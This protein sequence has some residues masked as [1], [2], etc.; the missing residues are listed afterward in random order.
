MSENIFVKESDMKQ[1]PSGIQHYLTPILYAEKGTMPASKKTSKN[2]LIIVTMAG[3]YFLRSKIFGNSKVRQFISTYE[4]IEI[5]KINETKRLI[6]CSGYDTYF[7]ADHADIAIAELLTARA[8]LFQSIDDPNP[9]RVKGYMNQPEFT[10]DLKVQLTNISVLRYYCLVAFTKSASNDQMLI[11][12][13]NIDE[14]FSP[15]VT[16]TRDCVL[17]ENPKV[18]TIPL[19][20]IKHIRQIGFDNVEPRFV[21]RVVHK[22]LKNTE[23][24]KSIKLMNYTDFIPEQLRF[25]RI[26]N[27]T[28]SIGFTK[29]KFTT[30]VWTRIINQFESLESSILR[31]SI[32]GC[33]LTQEQFELIVDALCRCRCFRTLEMLEIDSIKFDGHWKPNVPNKSTAVLQSSRFLAVYSI[34]NWEKPSSFSIPLFTD[35]SMLSEICLRGQDMSQQVDAFT[36][37]PNIRT[38][39]L[40]KCH[41]TFQSLRAFFTALSTCNRRINLSLAN[42]NVPFSH[43]DTLFDQINTVPRSR[44]L[45]EL[46]WSGNKIPDKYVK[47]LG[48]FF[49][50]TNPIFYLS[51]DCIFPADKLSLLDEFL[52]SSETKKIWGIS[53]KGN[54]QANVGAKLDILIKILEKL[55][56]LS[57]LDISG[58]KITAEHFKTLYEFVKARKI[59]E[60]SLDGSGFTTIDKLYESY[61]TLSGIPTLK[62]LGRPFQDLDRLKANVGDVKFKK[63]REKIRKFNIPA[64]K[65]IRDMYYIT[66]DALKGFNGDSMDEY[67]KIYPRDLLENERP[68]AYLILPEPPFESRPSLFSASSRESTLLLEEIQNLSLRPP[69][70]PPLNAAPSANFQIPSCLGRVASRPG[71]LHKTTTVEESKSTIKLQSVAETEEFFKA[72]ELLSLTVDVED[73]I[74]NVDDLDDVKLKIDKTE[75]KP[76]SMRVRGAMP[77][78]QPPQAA[79][80]PKINVNYVEPKKVKMPA[81]EPVEATLI[82]MS[83]VNSLAQPSVPPK[84]VPSQFNIDLLDKSP[85]KNDSPDALLPPPLQSVIPHNNNVNL[86]TSSFELPGDLN[87]GVPKDS[88]LE[89]PP[90]LST[91]MSNNYSSNNNTPPMIPPMLSMN[92][93]PSTSPST[94]INLMSAM[95]TGLP[96]QKSSIPPLVFPSDFSKQGPPVIQPP[97]QNL[98]VPVMERKKNDEVLIQELPNYGAPPLNDPRPKKSTS[99]DIFAPTPD[100]ITVLNEW[101]V[102]RPVIPVTP[103]PVPV[104]PKKA[105]EKPQIPKSQPIIPDELIFGPKTVGPAITKPNPP[106]VFVFSN[107]PEIQPLSIPPMANSPI[108]IPNIVGP[109]ADSKP[110]REQKVEIKQQPIIDDPFAMP[111]LDTPSSSKPKQAA[112]NFAPNAP[113]LSGF[114]VPP[115][116][117]STL[118]PDAA[119]APKVPEIRIDF[120]E[121]EE[122]PVIAAPQQVDRKKQT[123]PDLIILGP[124]DSW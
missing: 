80:M 44:C 27:R 45:Y 81:N 124:P 31:F 111:V 16:I 105:N 82:D 63:F 83:E 3:I 76:A 19:S 115:M 91:L 11:F 36:L 85:P 65:R 112:V 119:V 9:I 94:N 28:I 121:K 64:S 14:V 38:L 95:K 39:D 116:L 1:V 55:P 17:P 23:N 34:S 102:E 88:S 62:C 92:D 68:D 20:C 21:C 110:E 101:T 24:I 46:D 97:M 122:A 74:D 67:Q 107:V 10:Q 57:V 78:F 54:E 50:Q 61:E 84:P 35:S 13:K 32:Q 87:S 59:R 22:L 52:S 30:T 60:L 15:N 47:S 49:L 86:A 114:I 2:C 96:S 108:N 109:K 79:N 40:A 106:Q 100:N 123:P 73:P 37:P 120:A 8:R 6:R 113:D 98:N 90:P 42:L 51:L 41:F 56:D 53:I 70:E 103:Q 43:W 18:L 118:D 12:F 75:L 72:C 7:V 4:I 29:C 58:Q 99:Y 77:V 71:A 66:R 104:E 5:E 26:L 117:S 33:E 25:N 89:F 48:E 93:S 69:R